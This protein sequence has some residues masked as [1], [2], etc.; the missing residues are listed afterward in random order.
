MDNFN[1]RNPTRILFGRGME[2]EAGPQARLH[3][4]KIL[5]HFGGGSIVKSGLHARI[6]A[7]LKTAGVEWEELPG[8]VP[9][10][11]L[12]LVREG[13]RICR[14]KGLGL[15]LAVG[16]GSVIDSAKAIAAGVPYSGDVWD[17][18]SGKAR[19]AEALPVG[20]V[21]TIPAA[22]SESSTGSVI[23]NEDGWFKRPLDDELLY[24]KFSILNP[25]L[26]FSLPSSQVANGAAD[27][28]AHLMERYFTNSR[29]V[30]LVD[31]LIE[32]T[33]RTVIDVAPRVLSKRD[34][35]DAW[36]E[37]MWAGTIAHNNL[38]STG[39]VGDW[40]SHDIEHEISAVYDVAHGAGLAVV[41]P[42]WMKHVYR[43]DP[44][45]FVQFAVRVWGVEQDFNEPERTALSGIA[46]L[47][48]FW[49]AIGLATHLSGL[50]IDASKIEE[51]AAK[52]S[53]G[54]TRTVGNFM[55]LGKDE[56]TEI[57]KLS[58]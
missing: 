49:Q 11:R 28:M 20:T 32:A 34:D 26:A 35:Y 17:F 12:S 14:E 52:A 31:R 13:I 57:L 15:I 41:F 25:E 54:G 18:Y 53:A 43:H 45:R 6:T 23:T 42:A 39:R 3:A 37:L 30:E 4:K 22:G 46:R 2:S 19:P 21:L 51:M 9:N 29:P 56:I 10:P 47:E 24:P 16:G 8:V 50:G 58:L 48:G 40:A 27:I 33:L 1:F 36:A 38:L 5:L 55:K 7:S 44:A